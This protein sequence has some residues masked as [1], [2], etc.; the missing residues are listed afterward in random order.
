MATRAQSE[1]LLHCCSRGL[2]V[3]RPWSV[4]AVSQNSPR[5]SW[6]MVTR[7]IKL[8]TLIFTHGEKKKLKLSLKFKYK[9]IQEDAY[10]QEEF[11]LYISLYI[12]STCQCT[13]KDESLSAPRPRT[14]VES[15]VDLGVDR[16]FYKGP[17]WSPIC[18]RNQARCVC[19]GR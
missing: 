8:L 19:Y 18:L 16:R 5:A 2:P 4:A 6:T 3:R 9:F 1:R 17:R 12:V 15:G 10:V 14:G 11:L 13:R 7:A